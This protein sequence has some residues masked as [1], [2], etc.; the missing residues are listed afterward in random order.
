MVADFVCDDIRDGEATDSELLLHGRKE[1]EIE[2]DRFVG[3]AIERAD[4][5]RL[6][7]TRSSDLRGEEAQ[8]RRRIGQACR[9]ECRSPFGLYV[10]ES[11]GYA[12]R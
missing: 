11:Y 4:F 8:G 6:R 7:T 2:I 10:V 1:G 9:S 3:G 12:L 5:G